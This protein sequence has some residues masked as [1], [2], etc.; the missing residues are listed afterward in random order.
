MPYNLLG[1]PVLQAADIL[2]PRGNLV[3]VGKDNESH[4]EITRQIARRFN[5]A[6]GEVF[7]LPESHVIG[8]TLVGHRRRGQDEQEPEQ[9]HLPVGRRAV[10]RKKVMGMY[11]DPKRVHANIPGTVDGNPVFAYHDVFNPDKAEVEDLK[12]RYREGAVGDVEVKE[13]LYEALEAFL[14]PVRERRAE[15]ESQTGLIDELIVQGTDRTREEA[16]VTLNDA[17]KAMGLTGVHNRIR[18]SAEKR[19]KKLAKAA[20]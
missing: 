13:R 12:A 14:A 16:R 8:D 15:Y 3:P 11:T 2:T 20:S 18:R 17:K 9:R 5:N 10:V 1:Y 7:P 4:V 19:R 6:Y